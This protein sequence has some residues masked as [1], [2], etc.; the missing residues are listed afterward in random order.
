MFTKE[1]IELAPKVYE[2]IKKIAER[3]GKRWEWEPERGDWFLAGKDVGIVIDNYEVNPNVF[4]GIGIY[5]DAKKGII[6]WLYIHQ[7]IPVPHWEKLEKILE[8]FGYFLDVDYDYH[9]PF[10]CEICDSKKQNLSIVFGYG[11]TR[12]EAVMEA[13]IRLGG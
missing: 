6:N 5:P 3:Q 11:N 1:E 10:C 12:Q 2:A 8:K 4:R 13:I 7:V 9:A